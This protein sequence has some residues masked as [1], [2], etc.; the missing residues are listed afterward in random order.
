M[1]LSTQQIKILPFGTTYDSYK[2]VFA[3]LLVE[4]ADGVAID[5]K[6]QMKIEP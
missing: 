4:D 2:N 5:A 1:V 6:D 3:L